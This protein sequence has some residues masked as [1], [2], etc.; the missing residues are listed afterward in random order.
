[1]KTHTIII[2]DPTK[3]STMRT[4]TKPEASNAGGAMRG[5]E[6]ASAMSGKDLTGK[7]K[8]AVTGLERAAAMS[9]RAMPSTGKPAVTGTANA[10]AAS[11]G[12]L[13]QAMQT[14][15]RRF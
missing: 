13:N 14:N 4:S 6:R 1:M 11:G 3:P 10:D 9:G 5:L 2:P 8:P 12:L 15:K 7:G